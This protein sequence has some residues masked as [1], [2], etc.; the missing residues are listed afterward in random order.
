MGYYGASVYRGDYYGQ[1]DYYRSP[2]GDPG[3]FDFLGGIASKVLPIAAPI[4]GG[5]VGGPFGAAIGGIA[6]G[7]LGKVLG[8]GA[9]IPTPAGFVGPGGRPPVWAAAAPGTGSTVAMIP[10]TPASFTGLT[11]G[12]PSGLTLGSRTPMPGGSRAFSSVPPLL[13]RPRGMH[14]RGVHHRRM[15]SL[16][17]RA[18]SRALRRA[19]GFQKYATKVL[20]LV[21][22]KKHVD[23]FKHPR[24]HKR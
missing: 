1:G 18:L 17:P 7:A 13:R 14:I 11:I 3:F 9:P 10:T 22:V 21:G 15:N 19:R 23:G 5:L 6:G 20:K 4:V 16:N 12:G 2:A 24:K 8:P